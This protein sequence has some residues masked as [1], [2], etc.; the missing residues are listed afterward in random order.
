MPPVHPC[1]TQLHTV[2]KTWSSASRQEPTRTARAVPAMSAVPHPAQPK[3]RIVG[4][5]AP[6]LAS[7]RTIL[8]TYPLSRAC[9]VPIAR[10]RIVVTSLAPLA[11]RV[12]SQI[13]ARPTRGCSNAAFC[14]VFQGR[15]AQLLVRVVAR[16]PGGHRLV[17]LGVCWQVRGWSHSWQAPLRPIRQP[18]DDGGWG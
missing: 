11:H 14:G 16:A 15:E 7:Q 6:L 10:Y 13:P 9:G 18:V 4:T 5:M 17:I 2:A 8:S 12:R 3:Q 1:S